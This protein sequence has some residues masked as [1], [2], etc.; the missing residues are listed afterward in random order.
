MC[1]IINIAKINVGKNISMI[2]IKTYSLLSNNL[3]LEDDRE[4]YTLFNVKKAY[5][6]QGICSDKFNQ[7]AHN[8][9]HNKATNRLFQNY[10]RYQS[11]LYNWSSNQAVLSEFD[12]HADTEEQKGC[13]YTFRNSHVKKLYQLLVIYT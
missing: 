10:S 7:Q 9:A 11:F 13:V 3:S 1:S 5:Y 6:G 12:H 2:F 4:V 8:K